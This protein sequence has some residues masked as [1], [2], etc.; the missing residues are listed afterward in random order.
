[1]DTY[2]AAIGTVL[3][4]FILVWKMTND[5]RRGCDKKMA[6]CKKECDDH[7]TVVYRRFDEHKDHMETTHVSKEVHDI[8]YEQMKETMDEIK[9]DVKELLNR[10]SSE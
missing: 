8:K 2:Y 4:V 6:D 7:R 1:V 5:V 10:G 3:S 9:T